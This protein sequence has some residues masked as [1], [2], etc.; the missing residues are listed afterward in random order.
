MPL[1]LRTLTASRNVLR[2]TP[3][4]SQSFASK[5]N[6]DPMGYRPDT[7]SRPRRSTAPARRLW[8]L[9]SFRTA[10]ILESVFPRLVTS[11]NIVRYQSMTAPSYA[12]TLRKEATREYGHRSLYA[13]HRLH[14]QDRCVQM[15]PGYNSPWF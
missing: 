11:G 3:S 2:P 9:P 12:Q 6:V 8:C 4:A 5:G 1:S 13:W 7:M 10:A 14:A 15:I